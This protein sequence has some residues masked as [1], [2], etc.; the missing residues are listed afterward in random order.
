MSPQWFGRSKV[1]LRARVVWFARPLDLEPLSCMTRKT[2]PLIGRSQPAFTE[3]RFVPTKSE[4][5][6]NVGNVSEKLVGIQ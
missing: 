4:N 5:V 1:K 3:G 2:K 6:N